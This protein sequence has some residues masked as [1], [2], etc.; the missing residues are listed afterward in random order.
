MLR[1][2]VLSAAVG[3]PAVLVLLFLDGLPRLQNIPLLLLAGGIAALGAEEAAVLLRGRGCAPPKWLGASLGPLVPL[4]V[5]FKRPAYSDAVL[6]VL[7]LLI[8]FLVLMAFLALIAD[9]VKRSWRA[10]R[11]FGLV[12]VAAGYIGGMLAILLLLRYLDTGARVPWGMWPVLLIFLATWAMDA[13]AYLAGRKWGRHRLCPAISPGKT[14]EGAIF[15]LIS[16][17]IITT[18][19]LMLAVHPHPS[20]LAAEGIGLALGVAGEAGDL[21]ESLFK[22]RVGAKDSGDII[23]GHGGI[24]DRFDSMLLAAPTLYLILLA[25]RG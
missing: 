25:M 11:D 5:Y 10:L 23:P 21:V 16:S 15:G 13:A 7:T 4:V 20:V 12:V 6:L 22:R 3:I 14:I 1:T 8:V 19:V 17:M 2:R 18:A 9:V 24:L